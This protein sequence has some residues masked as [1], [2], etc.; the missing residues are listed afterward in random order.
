MV[1]TAISEDDAPTAAAKATLHA[2]N[3]LIATVSERA[4]VT[5]NCW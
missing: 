3:R 4:N 1:G 2:L 5:M